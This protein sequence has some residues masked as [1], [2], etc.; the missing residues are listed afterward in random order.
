MSCRVLYY[1]GTGNSGYVAGRIAEGLWVTAENLFERI[2]NSDYN[3]ITGV[4]RLIVVTPTY[5][6]QI[7][8][9]VSDWMR[10][11]RFEE[12]CEVYFVLTCGSGIG[13]A[14]R[15]AAALS[16]ECGL[17]YKGIGKVVM[18]ENY[19]A[20]FGVPDREKSLA[21]IDKAEPVIDGIIAA[22][23]EGR[24]LE[25]RSG[26][27]GAFESGPVNRGFYAGAIKDAKFVVSDACVGCGICAR[28]CIMSNIT[29]EEGRP[30]WHGNC[31]H[32]MACICG[33]PKEAIE[34]GK[35]SVGKPR[36]K[37]PKGEE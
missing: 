15:Y 35:A 14:G 36:Y 28:G 27:I 25:S 26:L 31:T 17:K 20:M 5:A 32:C 23:R 13:A 1:T 19:L 30:V 6:W 21:I 37:C 4:S 29:I 24:E 10:K 16:K 22:V 2:K 34:Y 12:G 9:I 11:I 8:H 18:P 3:E 33:C 7:P